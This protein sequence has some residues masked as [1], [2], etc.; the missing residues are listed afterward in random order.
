MQKFLEYW[1][2]AGSNPRQPP[3]DAGR[4]YSAYNVAIGDLETSRA[5]TYKLLVPHNNGKA[6]HPAFDSDMIAEVISLNTEIEEKKETLK[7]I[8]NDIEAFMN[9]AGTPTIA[10]LVE[11][12]HQAQRRI[13]DA[14]LKAKNETIVANNRNH[15][16]APPEVQDLP[17]VMAANLALAEVR[18]EFEP[19][20]SETTTKLE[21]ARAIV[22]KYNM[23]PSQ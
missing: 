16:L 19:I 4:L 8:A 11:Q 22:E 15:R 17:T 14:R 18:N 13:Q 6:W 5:K 12:L 23:R 3:D 9:V 7:A 20:I 21:A 1:A 2:A 10:G